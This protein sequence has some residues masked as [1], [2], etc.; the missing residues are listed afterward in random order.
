MLNTCVHNINYSYILYC[1]ALCCIYSNALCCVVLYF[2]VSYCGINALV[3]TYQTT[4]VMSRDIQRRIQIYPY[5]IPY[6]FLQRYMFFKCTPCKH[7]GTTARFKVSPE[8][9]LGMSS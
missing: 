1:V 5:T 9:L 8:R 3:D 6:Y 2:I 7:R 4:Y